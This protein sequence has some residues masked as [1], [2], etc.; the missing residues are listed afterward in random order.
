MVRYLGDSKVSAGR[1]RVAARCR[2]HGLDPWHAG[3]C[4]S[5]SSNVKYS[6]VIL[7]F[8]PKLI[9]F[10][11]AV[12]AGAAVRTTACSLLGLNQELQDSTGALACS[13]CPHLTIAE[14]HCTVIV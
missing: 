10:N 4:V 12:A 9:P 6:F 11:G 3:V 8:Y 14:V 13:E 2:L 5:V 1:A 7:W